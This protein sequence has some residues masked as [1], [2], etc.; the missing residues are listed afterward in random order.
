[1]RDDS[2]YADVSEEASE[3]MSSSWV[4]R[5]PEGNSLTVVDF[6]RPLRISIQFKL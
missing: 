6:L 1:M 2:G 3:S 5:Q 4:L